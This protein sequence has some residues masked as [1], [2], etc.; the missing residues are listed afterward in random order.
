MYKVI[1]C[2]NMKYDELKEMCRKARSEKVNCLCTELTKNKKEGEN[3]S[4]NEKKNTYIECIHKSEAFQ[5]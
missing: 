4:S 2:Y 3:R 1:G 5:S